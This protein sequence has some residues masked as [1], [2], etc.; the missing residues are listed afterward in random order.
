M[1]TPRKVPL[2][3]ARTADRHDLYQRAV[4]SPEAEIDFVD[5][6]FKAIR[7]R[8]AS[9]L[10]EDFCGTGYTS[11]EW[12]RR[13]VA[14]R[15]FGLDL[16][17]PTIDWGLA[18]NAAGL[19]DE[20]RARL[21]LMNA[22]VRTPPREARG[23]D[24]ALAM[25]FSYWIFKTRDELRGYFSVVRRSL[26]P[27]GVFFL[28]LYAGY[29]AMKVTQERR[30][31]AGGFTYVWDQH[32]YNPVSGDMECRIHFEFRDGTRLRN[33][34]T[35]H[36]RLWTMP[37]VRELLLEAGFKNVV[38]YCE[39]ENGNGG[40]DGRFRAASR[41]PADAGIIAYLSAAK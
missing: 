29:E 11:C 38:T 18:H 39:G 24:I 6:R 16:D 22:D 17:Q 36:W 23:V 1:A 13:R 41:C 2:P 7:G 30:R 4:Q 26:A 37:E 15:A 14:N 21:H 8:R 19:N 28:D 34:F 33:A 40:G 25:N 5:S 12:V 27:D 31:I 20:Q 10:R 32:A 3:T 35:Y 9:T